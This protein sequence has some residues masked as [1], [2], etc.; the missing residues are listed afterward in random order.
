M[1]EGESAEEAA[2]RELREETGYVPGQKLIPLGRYF[3][4]AYSIVEIRGFLAL[5]CRRA[6][7]QAPDPNEFIE[8]VLK[9]L[10]EFL[11][12]LRAGDTTDGEVSWSGLLAA[13][14][15]KPQFS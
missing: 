10:P 5:D 1:D 4:G 11:A 12:Q 9:T 14:L 13:G 2:L 8:V 3:E 7:D 15:L 6:H